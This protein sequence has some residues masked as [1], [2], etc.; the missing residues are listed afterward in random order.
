MYAVPVTGSKYGVSVAN[1]VW[2][3]GIG[4]GVCAER[5]DREWPRLRLCPCPLAAGML[6]ST[7]DTGT[8]VD[9][10]L[11][12]CI[13]PPST[14]YKSSKIEKAVKKG[15]ERSKVDQGT[16]RRGRWELEQVNVDDRG[17]ATK[18]TA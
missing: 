9:M 13:P 16:N 6:P 3:T 5:V 17:I 15:G 10:F 11:C 18:E 4:L 7:P 1:G 8:P 14:K 12:D 2:G